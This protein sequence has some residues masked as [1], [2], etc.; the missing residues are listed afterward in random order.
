MAPRAQFNL[1][2][3]IK[4]TGVKLQRSRRLVA[5]TAVLVSI[6]SAAIFVLML[7]TVYGIQKKQLSDTD[8]DITSYSQKLAATENLD[9]I[10]TVQN[11]LT[12]LSGLHQNK[13]AVSRIFTYMPEVTP[14]NVNLSNL[15]L[16][17]TADTIQIDGTA[18]SQK[19]VNTFVDTLKFTTYSLGSDTTAK[20]AFPSVVLSSFGIGEGRASFSVN[21]TFDAVLF[22]SSAIDSSGNS[23]APKLDVPKLTSTRSVLDDP[24][25][26]LFNGQGG[27]Q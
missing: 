1:L 16:D 20:T 5:S 22:S 17:L 4:Q 11:Q 15:S 6:I 25:N 24:S 21:V 7:L 14:S 3:D 12:T 2:P 23:V 26:V 10:L 19:S 9:R 27:G 8:K 18:D 13:H